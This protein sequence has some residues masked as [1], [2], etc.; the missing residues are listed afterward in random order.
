MSGILVALLFFV[1]L[2]VILAA[3]AKQLTTKKKDSQFEYRKLDALFTP[4]ERSFLGI[5]KLAVNDET[6]VFGKVRVAD[7]ILP[8]KGQ[9]RREWQIAFNKI[10]SKHFDFLV[11]NKTDLSV[12]CAIELNDKS[13]NSK[14][15]QKRDRF[16]EAACDS[17]SLTLIQIPAKASYQVTEIKDIISARIENQSESTTARIKKTIS[18]NEEQQNTKH[19]PKCSSE[20]VLKVAKKG[21]NIGKEF[22]ACNAFPKCRYIKT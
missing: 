9:Q 18:Q 14:K 6:E 2:I 20:L 5:L 3:I 17:A 21:N 22:L 15:R 7:V 10:S 1:V 16:L 8:K 11:C 4:A 13:H 19:C 12:I